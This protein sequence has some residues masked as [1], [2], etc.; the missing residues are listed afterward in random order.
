[1]DSAYDQSR[2]LFAKFGQIRIAEW[3]SMLI[4]NMNLE[5]GWLQ[6]CFMISCTLNIVN[7]VLLNEYWTMSTNERATRLNLIYLE[8]ILSLR[9]QL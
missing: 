4:S 7:H 1:M 8:V 9:K 2:A 5:I 3:S 6:I